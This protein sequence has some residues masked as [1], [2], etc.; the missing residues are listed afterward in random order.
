MYG[1]CLRILSVYA[2][3]APSQP[4][5]ARVF[6]DQAPGILRQLV[7]GHHVW[8]VDIAYQ[9]DALAVLKHIMDRPDTHATEFAVAAELIALLYAKL[10]FP[11]ESNARIV[12]PSAASQRLT[13]T[14]TSSAG[15]RTS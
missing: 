14:R 7:A 8:R 12:R 6:A 2:W 13:R 5:C 10:L 4:V 1:T 11:D 3:L 15:L 9:Q